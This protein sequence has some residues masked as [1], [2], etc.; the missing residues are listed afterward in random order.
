[1]KSEGGLAN[2][3]LGLA[4]HRPSVSVDRSDRVVNM[5]HEME[6]ALDDQRREVEYREWCKLYGFDPDDAASM[7]AYEGDYDPWAEVR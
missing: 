3:G 4:R 7:R 5:E 1:M 2:D 6:E